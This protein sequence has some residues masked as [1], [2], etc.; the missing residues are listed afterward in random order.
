MSVVQTKIRRRGRI[1]WL[2]ERRYGSIEKATEVILEMWN[3]PFSAET[4]AAHL[5]VETESEVS[6]QWVRKFIDKLREQQE[7]EV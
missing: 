2:L 6:G 3:T 5:R 4:I 7:A 1:L